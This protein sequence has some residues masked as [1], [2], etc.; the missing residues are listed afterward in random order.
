MIGADLIRQ[1][2][3]VFVTQP[4]DSFIS[5]AAL[6]PTVTFPFGGHYIQTP[7]DVSIFIP[8]QG[9]HYSVFGSSSFQLMDALKLDVGAR[10]QIYRTHQQSN[11]SVVAAGATVLDNFPTVS[12]DNAIRTYHAFTGGADLTY[13]FTPDQVGYVSYGHSFRPG[14]SAVGVT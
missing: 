2:D 1:L 11:L 12:A 5:G 6:S 7:V 3:P 14:S 10:Y 13:T 8:D 4:S 9:T